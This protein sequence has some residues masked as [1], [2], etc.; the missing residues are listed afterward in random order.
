MLQIP[1]ILIFVLLLG[2]CSTMPSGPSILA[3][4]GAG[5]SFE[6]FHKD[7]QSCRQLSHNQVKSAPAEADSKEVA[8]QDY[9]IVYTQCMY[10]KGH[11]V[12]VPGDLMYNARD[13]WRPPP[14]PGLPEPKRAPAR[15]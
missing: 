11:K 5:K 6:Q 1:I 8:Q 7:D 15:K 14:P 9:D 10:G 13:D 3:L 12:P 4:P 2:A